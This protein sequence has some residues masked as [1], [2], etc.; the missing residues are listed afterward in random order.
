METSRRW[1]WI[2]VFTVFFVPIITIITTALFTRATVKEVD[3]TVG[4]EG[5]LHTDSRWIVG[6]DG[7]RV[8]LACVNW[9][10]HLEVAVPEGLSKKPVDVISKGIKSMGFNCVRL[11]WPTLLVTN[12]S[13]ASLSVRSSFQKLGLLEPVA[14]V[15]TN[16]PSI[17]DLPLIQAFEA[18]V[19]NLGD[20]DVMVILDNHL[21]QPGWCCG[22]TDGNGFFTDKFF[23]PDQWISGLTKMATLFKGVKTVVGMSL[24]NELRGSKQNVNDWYKYMVK[25]AEAVH[26]AN[27]DVLVILSGLNF[28]TDL[29]FIRDRPVSVTFKGKLVFEVHRYGFTDGQ[30]W[31]DGNPNEVC[32]KVTETIKKTSAYLLDQGWPLFVSEFGGDLR[33][34]NVNDNRYLTCFLALLAE[35]DLDWAYWTLVGSYYIREGVVGME[36]VYGVLTWDWNQVRSISFLNRISALQHPFRGPGIIE[37]NSYKLMFH[38]VTGL[39]VIRKSQV[40]TLTLGPCSSSDGWKYTS[41]KSLLVNDTN[42]CIHGERERKP[43]TLSTACSDSSSKWEVISDS[44]MHLSSKLSDGSNVC[45]D[46]DADNIIVTNTCKCLSKDNKCDPG[47][48]WFKL[49]D[50]GRRSISTTSTMSILDSSNLLWKPLSVM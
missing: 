16:N 49:I 22:N 1:W 45:L 34:T 11:T 26:A 30:A 14:G 50:S 32:G 24:R 21:T 33:G 41:Q 19:K 35:L 5:L 48:Q 9:V 15:Q 37:G 44:N 4:V 39:C 31:G 12:D 43:A 36:E 2:L 29:S 46:V 27:S 47:T 8:K 13:L 3:N 25:G 42:L 10:S 40:N 28:D 23:N 20:N 17:I 38:P 7:R 6:Q 18:M